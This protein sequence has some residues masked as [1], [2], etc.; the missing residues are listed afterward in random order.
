MAAQDVVSILEEE[1]DAVRRVEGG[2]RV[3]WCAG[4]KKLFT[5]ELLA[6]ERVLTRLD[7]VVALVDA[8][9]KDL[10]SLCRLCW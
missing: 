9:T 7:A 3:A 1:L 8:E 6:D 10:D 2:R 4:W 5:P